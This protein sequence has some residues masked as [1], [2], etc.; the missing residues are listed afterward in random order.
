MKQDNFSIYLKTRIYRWSLSLLQY[1]K[2]I[3][4]EKNDYI[5]RVIFEQ[6][7]RSGTSVGANYVE[8]LGASSKKDFRRFLSY[9]LKSGNESKYWLALIKDMK[10]DHTQQ[11]NDAMNEIE[12]ITKI[13]GKSVATLYK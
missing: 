9:A 13:L 4:V 3:E 1:L 12:E 6:L 10:Y 8:A 7:V 2:K 5:Y 11:W